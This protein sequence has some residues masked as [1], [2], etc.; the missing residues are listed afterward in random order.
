[1]TCMGQ[2]EGLAHWA[3]YS[4][5]VG[6]RA[7]VLN[8]SFSF[9]SV[10]SSNVP[11]YFQPTSMK[12]PCYS[13]SDNDGWREMAVH[14]LHSTKPALLSEVCLALVQRPGT[15]QKPVRHQ[16]G[17]DVPSHFSEQHLLLRWDHL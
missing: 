1:M 15:R 14:P 5:P 11:Y 13:C 3:C 7:E 10:T 2:D 16:Q 12:A 8:L 17:D 4:G 6:M 9:S